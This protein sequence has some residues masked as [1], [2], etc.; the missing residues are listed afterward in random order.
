[1]TRRRL[2]MLLPAGLLAAGLAGAGAWWATQPVA[3]AAAA[4]GG[5]FRLIDGDGHGVTDQSF[6]GKA[7]LVYFGYTHCPDACPTALQD[8]AAAVDKLTPAERAQVQVVFITVDPARDTPAV[9]K[10]YV[11]AFGPGIEGLTGSP[12]A[13]AQ[14]A[15]E[16]RVYYARH[17]EANGDYSM[18]HSSIIY[19]M[20]KQ[21]R[22]AGIL[23][24]GAPDAMAD[25]I[26]KLVG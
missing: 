8:M 7:M 19:V 20:D 3:S 25:S 14:A 11:S 2:M 16:Y 23:R 12:G 18:D 9:M 6:R 13:V 10:S 1:M 17:D 21:G 15:R 26:R 24:D 22:F 5:P 4:I